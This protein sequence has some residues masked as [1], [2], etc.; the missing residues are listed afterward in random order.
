MTPLEKLEPNVLYGNFSANRSRPLARQ[1]GIEGRL[2]A[3]AAFDEQGNAVGDHEFDHDAAEGREMRQRFDAYQATEG[4]LLESYVGRSV[5]PIVGASKLPAR[6]AA[7]TGK[8]SNGEIGI[9][10]NRAYLR[11][12]DDLARDH[13]L[14]R[15]EANTYVLAHEH[16]HAL[17]PRREYRSRID[18]ERHVE[19]TLTEYF[20]KRAA[21]TKGPEQQQ[22]QRLQATAQQ[23]LQALSK[24][25]DGHYEKMVAGDG[26]YRTSPPAAQSSA[27]AA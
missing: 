27:K 25:S 20:G 11:R 18:A 12:V 23:R 5:T 17:D 16:V 19:Q 6:A 9:F 8:L 13:D 3:M 1:Y 10:A 22:Y 2:D 15:E 24:M 7:A 4:K 14:S 21:E 26:A